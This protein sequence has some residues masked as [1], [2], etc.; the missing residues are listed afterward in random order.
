MMDSRTD[1]NKSLSTSFG[2]VSSIN[3]F[4][5]SESGPNAQT[6]LAANASQS[7]FCAKK[8][9]KCFFGHSKTTFLLSIS[10]PK[11]LSNGSA[12]IV[13]LFLLFGVS[14]KHFNAD[15]STTVSANTTT[16]SATLTSMSAY[17][18]R[19]SFIAESR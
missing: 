4:G 12:I 2:K 9:A 7:Y 5:P 14:A 18:S 10:T 13:I 8:F 1:I 6:D 19:K 11:P 15:V 16:G 3:T 17:T